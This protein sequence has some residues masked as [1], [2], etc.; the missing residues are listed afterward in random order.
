MRMLKWNECVRTVTENPGSCS[1]CALCGAC[2]VMW[3]PCAWSG[4]ES[5]SELTSHW[6]RWGASCSRS[7]SGVMPGCTQATIGFSQNS[8]HVLKC[9][10]PFSELF[11]AGNLAHHSAFQSFLTPTIWFLP[12]YLEFTL[13]AH[14]WLPPHFWMWWPLSSFSSMFL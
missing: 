6:W 8:V 13:K 10:L 3:I 7:L 1:L 9:G 11:S 4:A 2:A 14:H 5:P 12:L